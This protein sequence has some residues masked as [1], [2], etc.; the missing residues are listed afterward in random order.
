MRFT[1]E[2][3]RRLDEVRKKIDPL[4]PWHA[5]LWSRPEKRARDIIGR[6][7]RD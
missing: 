6:S 4:S 7:R 3:Q 2:E 5:A 1:A